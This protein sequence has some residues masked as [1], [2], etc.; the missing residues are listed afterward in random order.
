MVRKEVFWNIGEHSYF[1]YYPIIF[2]QGIKVYRV[3]IMD[4][5]K[6]LLPNWC[7]WNMQMQ[8]PQ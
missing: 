1:V 2:Y 6:I 7:Q 8:P 5:G 3:E 4:I